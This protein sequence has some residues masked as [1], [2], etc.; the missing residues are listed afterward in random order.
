MSPVACPNCHREIPELDSECPLCGPEGPNGASAQLPEPIESSGYCYDAV[1]ALS[2]AFGALLIW[3][4]ALLAVVYGLAAHRTVREEEDRHQ[5][6]E[7]G[8]WMAT[9]AIAWSVVVIPLVI[10]GVVFV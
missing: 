6:V 5:A 10:Y 9:I 3:P 4:L 8:G 7:K 2:L 1:A